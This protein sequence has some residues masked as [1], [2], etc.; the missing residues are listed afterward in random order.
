MSSFT[1]LMPT[2]GGQLARMDRAEFEKLAADLVRPQGTLAML[3]V[4]AAAGSVAA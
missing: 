2:S 4:V 3:R 1:S